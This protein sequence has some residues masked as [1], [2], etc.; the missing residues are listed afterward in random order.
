MK[1]EAR[2]ESQTVLHLQI[3]T[4]TTSAY[5]ASRD[6]TATQAEVHAR[7]G[8]ESRSASSQTFVESGWNQISISQ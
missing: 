5:K 8:E 3:A 4:R 7:R 1:I 6:S 2:H